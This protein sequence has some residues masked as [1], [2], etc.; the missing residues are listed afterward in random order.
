MGSSQ[1]FQ[2]IPRLNQ[3]YSRRT[4]TVALTFQTCANLFLAF[5][6]LTMAQALWKIFVSMVTGLGVT[7]GNYHLYSFNRALSILAITCVAALVMR[8]EAHNSDLDSCKPEDAYR[9][10]GFSLLL[11]A[12]AM[13]F[14]SVI[15]AVAAIFPLKPVLYLQSLFLGAA[16]FEGIDKWFLYTVALRT[17]WAPV[18][19]IGE[20]LLFVANSIVY[21]GTAWFA[22]Q[23]LRDGYANLSSG[24]SGKL[25]PRLVMQCQQMLFHSHLNST[26]GVIRLCACIYLG[27]TAAI[28]LPALLYQV[29]MHFVVG[30]STLV[31]EVWLESGYQA[32]GTVVISV[33]I[34]TMTY[35]LCTLVAGVS[36]WRMFRKSSQ[37]TQS[38]GHLMT[39]LKDGSVGLRRAGIASIVI[40]LFM[41]F[42]IPS[43]RRI[44]SSGSI[45]PTPVL[46]FGTRAETKPNYF[47]Y[48]PQRI[49][50]SV[51]QFIWMQCIPLMVMGGLSLLGA[52]LMK[53]QFEQ[54][55][56]T[57]SHSEAR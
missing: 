41:C 13:F 46:L 50:F 33:V 5:G 4:Q 16:V 39:A 56:D 49:S 2:L 9:R 23:M 45:H 7:Q 48:Q 36:S 35:L 20:L 54:I 25:I 43:D 19:G 17:K 28:V 47:T 24:G 55:E 12:V 8:S 52:S 22:L 29:F 53:K 14:Q 57:N 51:R 40:A 26:H 31:L 18:I 34:V 38:S 32:S 21:I 10:A 1:V 30:K 6:L 42:S 37:P 3:V 11:L 44:G 15:S 27:M